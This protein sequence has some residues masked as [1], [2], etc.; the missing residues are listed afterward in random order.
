MAVTTH[1]YVYILSNQHGMLYTGITNDLERRVR[2]HKSSKSPGFTQKYNINRLIYFE[3]FQS[4]VEAIAAEKRVKGW[5]R[6]KKLDL[7]RTQN[8]KF[9]DLTEDW[10]RG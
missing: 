8:P 6:K 7:I 2:E 5:T 9:A 10:E 3:E 4:R 1:Y